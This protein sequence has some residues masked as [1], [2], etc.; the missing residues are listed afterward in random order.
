MLINAAILA[1]MT[2]LA[3]PAGQTATERA[4]SRCAAI[5]TDAERLGCYDRLAEFVNDLAAET[6][7]AA[8]PAASAA[9]AAPQ[10][11][12]PQASAPQASAPRTRSDI[13]ERFGL[14][15]PDPEEEAVREISGRVV[16]LSRSPYGKAIVT[17]DNGQVWRQLDSDSTRITVSDDE[18]A[19]GMTATVKKGMLGSHFVKL[20]PPGRSFKAARVE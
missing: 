12:A 16:S 10:A 18:I 6:P 7:L 3:Q 20:D 2:A 1:A 11:A 8:A 17:L 5:E 9:R 14:N 13:V 19:G 15:R 4:L